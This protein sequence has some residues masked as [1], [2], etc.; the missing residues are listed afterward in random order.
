MSLRPY[1]I[2]STPSA[3]VSNVLEAENVLLLVQNEEHVRKCVILIGTPPPLPRQNIIHVI[4]W[5]RPSPPP[6][7]HTAS[8]QKLDG[9]KACERG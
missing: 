2:V 6:F 3:G 8:N 5:T 9:G 4:K 1:L 7:L